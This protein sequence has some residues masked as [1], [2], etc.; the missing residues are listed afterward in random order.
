ML[1]INFTILFLFIGGVFSNYYVRPRR[2]IVF[3]KEVPYN[4]DPECFQSFEEQTIFSYFKTKYVPSQMACLV[5]RRKRDNVANFLIEKEKND[6]KKKASRLLEKLVG[7]LWPSGGDVDREIPSCEG[8]ED[9]QIHGV[10]DLEFWKQKSIN[11]VQTNYKSFWEDH[12]SGDVIRSAQ[13]EIMASHMDTTTQPCDDFY[14]YACGNWE[15]NNPIPS[16]KIAYGTFEML[17]EALD[18]VLRKLLTS[19]DSKVE[20]AVL[21]TRYFYQSCMNEKVL[22]ERKETP[23]L[24]VLERLGGWSVLNDNWSEKGFDWVTLAAHLRKYNNDILLSEWVGPD[25]KDSEHYILQVDQTSLGL[26]TRDYYLLEENRV[27]LEAYHN[28]MVEL[29]TL[30]GTPYTSALSHAKLLIDFET[31]LAEITAS[32]EDRKNISELYQRMTIGDMAH[33]FPKINWELYF[34]IILEKNVSSSEPVVVFAEDYITRL[35]VLVENTKPNV[36]NGYLLWRFVRHR[37]NDLDGRFQSAKQTFYQILFGREKSPPRWKSCVAHVNTNMGISLGAVFVEKYFDE[38]SK[39]DTMHIT[40]D[41]MTSFKHLLM[42]NN[43][44]EKGTKFLAMEKLF[45]MILRIGYPDYILNATEINE[46]YRSVII[47]PDKYF[48]NTL[49]ILKYITK[50]EHSRLGTVV[51]KLLWN[52]PPAVVNAFYSRNRN[53]ILFPAGIL[54]PPFYHRHFPRALNFGGIGVVIGHEMT[55]GFDD[56]GRLFDKDGNLHRWWSDTDVDAFHNR[57]QCLIDQYSQYTVAE[58]AMQVR[59]KERNYYYRSFTHFIVSFT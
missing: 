47:T 12:S 53:Q 25:I 19:E 3:R 41:I 21:K 54:Q 57:T 40:K 36:L 23:L 37:A 8:E 56:K 11:N 35:V 14:Q 34:N 38:N 39:N 30:L 42:K 50:V 5:Q 6:R 32:P 24:N 52:T 27:Y 44:L 1:F 9:E 45:S 49:N 26:P 17:R 46:K 10:P 58:V 31:S 33:K 48:E 13:G 55:H 18:E 51:D 7:Y 59:R 29:L 2:Q 20:P 22:N 4:F 28:Y 16:D 15:K 43:W